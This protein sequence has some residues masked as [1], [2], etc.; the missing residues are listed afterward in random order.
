M[1]LLLRLQ[2]FVLSRLKRFVLLFHRK[3]PLL[4]LLYFLSL[5]LTRSFPNLN[6]IETKSSIENL[7]KNCFH[8]SSTKMKKKNQQPMS[9]NSNLTIGCFHLNSIQSLSSM[10]NCFH[11]SLMKMIRYLNLKNLNLIQNLNLI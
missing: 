5:R 3:R 8:L 9:L 6:L 4:P 11:L 10:T 1:F 2:R 7:T